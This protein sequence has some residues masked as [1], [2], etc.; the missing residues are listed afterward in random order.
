MR[1]NKDLRLNGGSLVGFCDPAEIGV[2]DGGEPFGLEAFYF[3]GV[4]DDVAQRIE[5]R[6][7]TVSVLRGQFCL[8]E[9]D[10]ADNAPAKTR[11]FIDSDDHYAVNSRVAGMVKE[12]RPFEAL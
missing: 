9:I 11:I 6:R 7:L 4:M 10:R 8:R 1:T 2:R 3:D 5:P 12:F